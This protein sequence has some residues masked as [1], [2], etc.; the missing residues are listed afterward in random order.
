MNGFDV[1]D[2]QRLADCLQRKLNLAELRRIQCVLLRATLGSSAAQI[3]EIL[4]WSTETVHVLH[5]RWRREGESL[6]T[7]PG[8]GGRRHARMT[9]AEEMEFLLPF[10]KRLEAGGSFGVAE[11]REALI[12][13]AG[14]AI[15]VSAVHRLLT[16]NSLGSAVRK[17][18]I[19]ARPRLTRPSIE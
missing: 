9:R 17:Q 14:Q 13:Q 7:M 19:I 5:S 12:H 18:N 8:S 11:V 1:A 6:F 2:V 3:A 4:G 15:S 16:R 10:R